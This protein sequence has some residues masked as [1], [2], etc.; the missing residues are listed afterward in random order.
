MS[1]LLKAQLQSDGGNK[2]PI[3]EEDTSAEHQSDGLPD[4]QVRGEEGSGSEG[5]AKPLEDTSDCATELPREL[6]YDSGSPRCK[7]V[8][9][10]SSDTRCETNTSTALIQFVQESSIQGSFQTELNS[11]EVKDGNEEEACDW[12]SLISGSSDLFIFDSP[13]VTETS[14]G[15]LQKSQQQEETNVFASLLARFPTEQ[16]YHLQNSL[17]LG[18]TGCNEA[19]ETA[20]HSTQPTE[21]TELQQTDQPSEN[22]E[23]TSVNEFFPTDSGEKPGKQV[24]KLYLL[25]HVYTVCFLDFVSCETFSACTSNM[26]AQSIWT[27]NLSLF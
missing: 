6:K 12:Q 19:L 13:N 8:T 17:Q 2:D 16:A 9:S 25:D 4:V 27:Q 26:G 11:Q 21:E 22:L 7:A 15:S 3:A 5:S 24:R 18:S 10:S 14:K 1:D 23:I 20:Q